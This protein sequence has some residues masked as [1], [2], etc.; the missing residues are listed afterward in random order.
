MSTDDVR[1]RE[2]SHYF[3]DQ[4]KSVSCCFR[5]YVFLILN[6][7]ILDQA[8]RDDGE[9]TTTLSATAGYCRYGG[10]LFLRDVRRPCRGAEAF[11]RVANEDFKIDEKDDQER[12]APGKGIL[13]FDAFSTNEYCFFDFRNRN[14]ER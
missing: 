11:Y 3:F 10:L 7:A 5:I 4:E 9:R 1:E 14:A 13:F 6:V 12:A 2:G 8:N